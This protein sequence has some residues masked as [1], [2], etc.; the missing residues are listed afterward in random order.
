VVAFHILVDLTVRQHPLGPGGIQQG[1]VRFHLFW[2]GSQP[3]AANQRPILF[4]HRHAGKTGRGFRVVHVYLDI[5]LPESRIG[6]SRHIEQKKQQ[7]AH[8]HGNRQSGHTAEPARFSM[9][10]FQAGVVKR[11]GSHRLLI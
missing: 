1:G 8:G 4:S 2:N 9:P 7:K 10:F 11:M 6:G 5:G 3:G